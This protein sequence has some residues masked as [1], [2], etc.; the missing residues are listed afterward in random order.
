MTENV[1]QRT[2][3]GAEIIGFRLYDDF[4]ILKTVVAMHLLIMNGGIL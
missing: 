4:V 1:L 3:K 2:Q